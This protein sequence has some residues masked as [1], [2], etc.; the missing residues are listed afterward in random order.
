MSGHVITIRPRVVVKPSSPAIMPPVDRLPLPLIEAERRKPGSIQASDPI[1]GISPTVVQVG[2]STSQGEKT[3]ATPQSAKPVVQ[4]FQTS[5]SNY[6]TAIP[7]PHQDTPPDKV[8]ATYTTDLNILKIHEAIANRF[9]Y[10]R[11]CLP[12]KKA[13]L[14]KLTGEL[15]FKHWS[16][17]E[18]HSLRDR[19]TALETEIKT[20]SSGSAWNDY[21]KEVSPILDKYL[22]LIT[23]EIKGIVSITGKHTGEQKRTEDPTVTDQRLDLICKY[24]E[25]AR[26]YIELD[27]VW[28]GVV[29]SKCP[30]CG[31]L[32]KDIHVDEDAGVH[33]CSCGFE[34]EN[35]SKTSSYKDA[36]R[37][38][39]GGRSGYEDR[40]TFDKGLQRYEGK[41]ADKIPEKLYEQLDQYYAKR[42]FP[43]GEQ[44][45]TL[46]FLPNGKKE[47]TSINLLVQG[48]SGTENPDF[49]KCIYLVA[50]HYW[51]WVLP[52]LTEI[53]ERIMEDYDVTQEV[54]NR[55]KTRDS[56]LNVNIR[57]YLHLKARD[58]PCE[59]EDFKI[60]SSRES[61]EYHQKMWKQMCAETGV[62]HTDII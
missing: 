15:G 32:F 6:Q 43:T 1:V 58:Y 59:W 42:G 20:I 24:L 29:E 46:P 11:G 2:R 18:V 53:R 39:I 57:I 27:V 3:L 35:L 25:I 41:Y 10:R 14:V 22:P 50:H 8:R 12:R 4:T 40:E 49:Y 9:G 47:G 55:I 30:G 16:I 38:N 45:K 51:G 33:I 56:S 21:V 5:K 37:V 13:E 7:E 48:L 17:I 19:I 23:N 61:L 31:K 52:D 54:Y 44:I 36:M 62:K 34:R 28:Q 60:L 26:G